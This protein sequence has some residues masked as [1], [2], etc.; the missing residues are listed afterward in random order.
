MAS[1][2]DHQ[3]AFVDHL[4]EMME[5]A[6]FRMMVM[7]EDRAED[8]SPRRFSWGMFHT[9]ETIPAD[10]G[11]SS[12]NTIRSMAP[13]ISQMLQSIFGTEAGDAEAP[14]SHAVV[15]SDEPVERWSPSLHGTTGQDECAVCLEDFRQDDP[16]TILSHCHHSFHPACID[17]ILRHHHRHCP[18][19]R[20]PLRTRETV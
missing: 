17:Q 4:H 6:V 20:S 16:V 15:V 7:Q 11:S 2:E 14:R 9:Y 3:N 5:Q 13:L 18:T 19:C 10:H 8:P 12:T 1:S